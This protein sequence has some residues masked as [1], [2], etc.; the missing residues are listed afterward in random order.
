MR[1]IKAIIEGIVSQGRQVGSGGSSFRSS[2]SSGSFGKH[3][4]G[5]D[6][7]AR[8]NQAHEVRAKDAAADRAKN[9]EKEIA[10]RNKEADQRRKDTMNMTK[11]ETDL[12][13]NV[14]THVFHVHLKPI[15]A[16]AHKMVDDNTSEPIGKK[17]KNDKFVLKVKAN[18]HNEA[19][20]KVAKYVHKNFGANN[21][22]KIEHK[23]IQ[24]EKME[25]ARAPGKS[26]MDDPRVKKAL[27]VHNTLQGKTAPKPEPE[28][29]KESVSEAASNGTEARSKMKNV[30]RMDD[31]NPQSEKST[32]SKTNSIKTKVIDEGK[33]LMSVPNFGLPSSLIAAA[34]QII[35]KKQD[36]DKDPKKMSGGK[37]AVDLEP[38]TN[39]KV[40]ES[41]SKKKH[42]T[43]K[44]D[45][46]K[47]LAALA[48]P[49]DKITHKDVLVG[50]GV[51]KEEE[52]DESKEYSSNK[53]TR[54][55]KRSEND[56]Q[57]DSA[58]V[59]NSSD[60]KF[61]S[62]MIDK[63]G[64]RGGA[65]L[66]HHSF[67]KK[68]TPKVANEEVEQ[69]DE[70]ATVKRKDYSWGKMVT[71]HDGNHQSFPLHPTHQ[72][73]IKNLSNGE[74]TKFK[75]ETGNEI[76]AHHDDGHIKL[77]F[78]KPGVSN[79][80]TTVKREKLFSEEVEQIDEISKQTLG[81]Y[82]KK[83]AALPPEKVKASREKGI[84]TA[85]KKLH[86]ENVE[87]VE[88]GKWDYPKYYTRTIE[89]DDMGGTN[90][91]TNRKRRKDFRKK[92]IA[93][94]HKELMTGKL[95]KEEVEFSEEELNRI[96]DIANSFSE[97]NLEEISKKTLGSYAKKAAVSASGLAFTG[98]AAHATPDEINSYNKFN[99]SLHKMGNRLRGINKAVDRLTRE[100]VDLEEGRGRPRKNPLP[101][102]KETE[103]DD[104][105]K[106]PMQQ[107]EKISHAME[108]NEP[109]FEHKDGSKSKL[110]RHLARHIVAIHNSMR[111]S[112][113]KDNF[114]QKVHA[115]RE[116]MKSEVSKHI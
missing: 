96:A 38:E 72:E 51:V 103:G 32:L 54:A 42:T 41:D 91:A 2:S 97:E 75:D 98:G 66:Q 112:Q 27:L 12:E 87:Q 93:K 50:R 89:V 65:W 110:S 106:H 108:G 105:H 102:G 5:I 111:T 86:K 71:V 7:G 63:W 1:D 25:E 77:R 45:K 39:D 18:D 94:R 74:K 23:G 83:V 30:A 95:K 82:V 78:T 76:E 36:D 8:R 22:S 101:D 48:S 14:G 90:A 69:I 116:S 19:R 49:K 4:H 16:R 104:T 55:I 26:L 40:D 80:T 115:N 114:A 3:D 61:V 13:E 100:E 11:E 20:N 88:E 35:E 10:K 79:K 56:W 64:E 29:K 21:V 109:H 15:D 113:E 34:R 44:T 70:G 81:S 99:K 62:K 84:E 57:K 53:M 52:I 6:I 37:T 31:E 47:K 67:F 92:I 46:E 58:A 33:P 68:H 60:P 17:P 24:E 59:K 73:K 28:K 85:S 107:L 43:P 9:R